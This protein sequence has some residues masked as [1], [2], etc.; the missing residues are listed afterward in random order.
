LEVGKLGRLFYGPLLIL[1]E[2]SSD[3]IVGYSARATR[4]YNNVTAVERRFFL[5][6]TAVA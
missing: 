1:V 4:E 3:G 2:L 5:Y 6:G